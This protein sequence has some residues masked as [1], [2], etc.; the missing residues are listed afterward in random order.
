MILSVKMQSCINGIIIYIYSNSKVYLF[1]Y[2][3]DPGFRL[4][5]FVFIPNKKKKGDYSL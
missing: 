1:Y 4:H 2:I 5:P 3:R